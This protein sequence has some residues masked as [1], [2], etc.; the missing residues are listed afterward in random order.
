RRSPWRNPRPGRRYRRGPAQGPAGA[1]RL[2][3][4]LRGFGKE[5]LINRKPT[6]AV[7]DQALA[8]WDVGGNAASSARSLSRLHATRPAALKRTRRAS[9]RSSLRGV[10]RREWPAQV[11]PRQSS[12]LRQLPLVGDVECEVALVTELRVEGLIVEYRRRGGFDE[13][14]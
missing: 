11:P 7:A 14:A 13:H 4:R 2:A 8:D 10:E 5:E 6:P 1:V 9:A 3:V 12:L